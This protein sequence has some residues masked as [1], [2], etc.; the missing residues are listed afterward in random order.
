SNKYRNVITIKCKNNKRF[1]EMMSKLLKEYM[2]NAK[3][4]T[5]NVTIDI[6]PLS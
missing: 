2:K 6:N 4:S 5:A 1:R 3:Y